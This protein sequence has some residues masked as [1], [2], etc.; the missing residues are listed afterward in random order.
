MAFPSIEE[1]IEMFYRGL[2]DVANTLT[3][4]IEELIQA[5][6]SLFEWMN[7]GTR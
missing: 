2:V 6:R 1:A 4:A 5:I 7:I 3:Q